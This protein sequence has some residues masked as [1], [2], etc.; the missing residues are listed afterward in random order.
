MYRVIDQ[1]VREA[2]APLVIGIRQSLVDV[3]LPLDPNN[4]DS[5]WHVVTTFRSQLLPFCE[6]FGTTEGACVVDAISLTQED[7][8]GLP[9]IDDPNVS[10]IPNSGSQDLYNSQIEHSAIYTR[11]KL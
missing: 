3:G 1:R 5:F 2:F 7:M 11:I 6:K 4:A 9:T 8:Y 10:S